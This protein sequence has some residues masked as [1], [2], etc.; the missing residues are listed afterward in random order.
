ML[1][2]LS[3]V[4]LQVHLLTE[5]SWNPAGEDTSVQ[6]PYGIWHSAQVLFP[7]VLVGMVT[8]RWWEACEVTYSGVYQKAF[9][10]GLDSRSSHSWASVGSWVLA[11]LRESPVRKLSGL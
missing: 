3:Y 1:C 6:V 8:R 9:L 4:C 2:S 11:W 5:M 10:V 7:H